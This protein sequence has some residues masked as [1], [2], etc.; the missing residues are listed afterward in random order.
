MTTPLPRTL[1]GTAFPMNLSIRVSRR[2]GCET[3]YSIAAAFRMQTIV[4]EAGF[5]DTLRI[6]CGRS[7]R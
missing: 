1:T 6:V 7:E 5:C 4:A 3:R 2:D